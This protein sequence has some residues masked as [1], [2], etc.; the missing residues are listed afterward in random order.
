MPSE[1]STH[2]LSGGGEMGARMREHDWRGSPL[3]EPRSWP[4]SLR[5][6][7]GI[8]LNSKFPMVVCWGPELIFFYNDAYAPVLGAREPQA[9]G[10]RFRDLWFDIWADV[11]PLAEKAMAGEASWF[12]DLPLVSTRNGFPEEIFFTFSYSP[13]RDESGAVGGMFCACVETTEKVRMVTA[14]HESE[15][16]LQF[17]MRAGR[18][19]SWE[20]LLPQMELV[21][22]PACK[23]NFGRAPNAPFTW[24]DLISSIHPDDYERMQ[25]SVNQT[26][27]RGTDYDVEYRVI[28]PDG[29]Q[30]DVAVQ[31]QRVMGPDRT[32]L[33]MI[34]ITREITDR[35]RTEEQLRR[36]NENLEAQVEARTRERDR[37]WLV[38]QDLLLVTDTA[39]VFLNVNPAWREVLGWPESELIGKTSRWLEHPEDHNSTR[40]ELSSL[41]AGGRTL[42]FENRFRHQDG[43]YRWLSWTAGAEQ[44]LIYAVARDVTAEKSAADA[45]KDAEEALRQAQKMEA[46]GQLTGGIAHDFNNLLQGIV[47]SLG[48]VQKLVTLGRAGEVDRFI[49]AAMASANRAAALTHRLLAFSRRQPLAPR[50]VDVN[51]L[52]A[53]MEDL[54]RRTLGPAVEMQLALQPGIWLTFCDHNQLENAILNLAINA[55]D[56]IAESGKVTLTTFNAQ[57]EGADAASHRDIEPGHYVCLSITDTGSGMTREV[58]SRAFDPFFTTKPQGR[59]TGLGLSM[60]YGFTRQS[61]G[62]AEIQSKVGVGTTVTLY[63]PRFRG[64]AENAASDEISPESQ[65]SPQGEVILVVEDETIIRELI[66]NVLKD[67]GYHVLEAA[68]GIAGLRV[69]KSPQTI[70]LLLTDIGMPGLNGRQIAD[71]ARETRPE[72]KVLFM[73]GYAENATKAGGFLRPGMQMLTKPFTMDVLARRVRDVIEEKS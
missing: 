25:S 65:S 45:L 44:G 6:A 63:L 73:T 28:W 20:L 9:L 70:D 56:A 16:R 61:G 66:V 15:E 10:M 69:L 21:A 3:G 38:S 62:H 12:E 27:T 53:S 2:F 64:H 47:G 17:S 14:L 22:T 55:R 46:V 34:G 43:S 41:A 23:A 18:L 39:G 30:H 72:L 37:I 50:S 68:D 31:A 5:V 4:H 11:G 13:I 19:G 57:L 32:V 51:Q 71:A 1:T 24:D 58:V 40:S 8:L 33:K 26:V 29:T 7:L 52:I 35:L 67:L 36:L 48:V 54:L 42:R 49:A 59:G 60:I